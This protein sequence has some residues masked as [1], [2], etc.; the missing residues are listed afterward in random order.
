VCAV[1]SRELIFEGKVCAVYRS[2]VSVLWDSLT[3]NAPAEPNCGTQSVT[4]RREGNTQEW[5]EQY[6]GS[7]GHHPRYFEHMPDVF[8]VSALRVGGVAQK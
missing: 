1:Q 8:N 7:C 6:L 4:L 5:A 3:N 2:H